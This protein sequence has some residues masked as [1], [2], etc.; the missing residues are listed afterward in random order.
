MDKTQIDLRP[1]A[2]APSC[3]TPEL[4]RPGPIPL[5]APPRRRGHGRGLSRLR[6]RQGPPRRHQSPGRRP[7]QPGLHRP[8][9]P[10]GPQRRGLL[11]HPNIVR[12][13]TAGQDPATGRHY[14]VL[15]Y[16]DGPSAHALL[17]APGPARRRATPSTSRWTWPAP[18]ST[19]TRATS[20]TATSSRTTSS[21]P[22]PA[23]PSCRPRP[24]QAHRRSQPPDGRA[25]GLRHHRTTCPTSRRSTPARPTAAATSTPWARRSTTCSPASCLSRRQ[26]P[27]HRGEKEPGEFPACQLSELVHSAAPGSHPEPHARL[28]ARGPLPVG[29]RFGRGFGALG[30]GRRLVRVR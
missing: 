23:W 3:A 28:P 17:A 20:S 30:T 27:R 29:E 18:W 10:R 4:R 7:W 2:A 6:P 1:P 24:G 5:A 26:P 12:T 21:S 14:L 22:A 9:L 15:E 19:P 16:V 11:N 13:L 8:L 25:P